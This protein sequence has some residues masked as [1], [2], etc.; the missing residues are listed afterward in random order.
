MYIRKTFKMK[1]KTPLPKV[2][3]PKKEEMKTL[4]DCV[5][6]LTREGFETQ[7]SVDESGLKSLSTNRIYKPDEVRVVSFY[8]FEG[9]SDPADNSIL[10][11]IETNEGE[12]GTVTDAYGPYGDRH[13]SHFMEQVTDI[14]KKPHH[15]DHIESERKLDKTIK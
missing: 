9:I 11:A 4:S 14:E 10:Y 15:E 13:I 2:P 3:L 5:N 6:A 7:F 8:R 1:D 12:L